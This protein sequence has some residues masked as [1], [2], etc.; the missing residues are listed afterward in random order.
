MWVFTEIGFFS[1]VSYDEN[2]APTNEKKFE[3]EYLDSKS[4]KSWWSFDFPK[5]KKAAENPKV[6]VRA[7]V[8]ADLEAL[9][10]YFPEKVEI[11]EWKARDYPYRV[12]VLQDWWA[13]AISELSEEIGYTNFKNRVTETQGHERHM[14]YMSVWSAMHS[15]E[16]KLKP[17]SSAGDFGS[18]GSYGSYGG[19]GGSS[20]GFT[21]RHTDWW[22]KEHGDKRFKGRGKNGKHKNG[23]GKQEP[24]NVELPLITS[25]DQLTT[26]DLDWLDD[27]PASELAAMGITEGEVDDLRAKATEEDEARRALS[28]PFH[29][30][31]NPLGLLESAVPALQGVRASLPYPGRCA[32]CGGDR[33]YSVGGKPS[34]LCY[35]CSHPYPKSETK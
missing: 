31:A 23:K 24:A 13:A 8:R 15:A 12:I 9:L 19:Y 30:D 18:G 1:V 26:A 20:S 35:A 3:R 27:M 17:K 28:D 29:V 10:D 6:M 21:S 34:D 22:D 4:K 33:D 32:E 5:F 16:S 2:R 14:L 7:R 25:T 11:T